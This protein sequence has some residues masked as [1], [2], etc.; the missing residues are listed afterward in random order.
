MS[1]PRRDPGLAEARTLD[2][3]DPLRPL[4]RRFDLPK[5]VIYLD[6]NSLGAAPRAT[7]ARLRAALREE[8][9]DGL[10]RSWNAHDW[11]G[12][13]ARIGAKIAQLIG[14]APNEVIVADSTSVNLFKLIV[15]AL[16]HRSPRK[17]IVA[18][19][20]DFPTDGYVAQGVSELMAGVSLRLVAA[21]RLPAAIDTGV[22]VVVLTEVNYRTG[23]R[24]DMR[25]LTAQAHAAGA[26]IIWDLSHSAG[27]VEV[28]LRGA[29]ADLAVG[30]GYKYL[31]GGP[32]APAYL[33]VAERLQSEL[34]S[35]LTGWM[36]HADPFEFSQDYRPAG[37][38]ER[39]LCGTPPVLSLL[40][41]ECGI[42]L[43]DGIDMAALADKGQRLCSYFIAEV[44]TRC[45]GHGLELAT[46]RDP[47]RRGSQVSF[48][49]P[50]AWAIM[51]A[52]IERGVIGDFRAPDVLRCGFTPI[53]LGFADVWRAVEILRDI[54][55]T[56]VWREARFQVRSRVT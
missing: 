20:G 40:A 35:P 21:D 25:A 23:A 19:A 44:E 33:F 22:A 54:L 14:A 27:A 53:Y 16:R 38:I 37:G 26:L 31:N 2:A 29:C 50:H 8:W 12:A 39:F 45:A 11:I 36:G 48:R 46:P 3:A 52:M 56:G 32:G 9:A 13:P 7:H 18:E 6:G 10:I 42:D 28:D 15:A 51:Q 55:E 43:F 24:H 4:R 5:G 34:A 30:C 17:A 49:H 1:R 41:L 47:A